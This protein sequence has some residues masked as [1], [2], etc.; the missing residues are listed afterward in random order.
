MPG[1]QTLLSSGR[2]AAL[3]LILCAALPL[4]ADEERFSLQGFATLG[5]SRSDSRELEFVRDLSQARGIGREWSAKIDSLAGLQT[6]WRLTRTLEASAQLVS[7]YRYDRSY[8][9]ELTWAYLKYEPWPMLSLRA[10]RLGTDFFMLADSRMVGYS[11][12]TVRPP[13]D[14][15]WHLPFSS[16]DGADLS[17]SRSLG[18]DVLRGKLFYGTTTARLPLAREHWDI[19]GSAMAGGYLD[20]QSGAWQ[21]RAGYA[22]LRFSRDLPLS[23][24]LAPLL[25]PAQLA[26]TLAYLKT[27]GRRAGYYSLGLVHDRGPWLLQWML[28]RIEQES[29]VFESSHAASFLLAYRSGSLTPYFGYSLARSS[30]KRERPSPLIDRIMADSHV[31]QRTT[32][33]GLRW[34]FARNTALKLQWDGIR[35]SPS[36]LFPFRNDPSSGQWSGRMN[37]YSLTLDYVF[38]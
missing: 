17:L 37:V 4:R 27:S 19:S 5:A 23:G 16:I 12:P 7:R 22:A 36:S 38:R 32:T 21:W 29:A 13:G 28:N 26:S 31:D 33:L 2:L 1:P 35:A 9:P 3:L 34:D 20:Y 8:V 30:P 24:L 6:G 25:P 10:G 18:D 11:Y 14:F 15:F